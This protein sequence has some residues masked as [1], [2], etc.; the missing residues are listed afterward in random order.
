MSA[1]PKYSPMQEK[2]LIVIEKGQERSRRTL[3]KGAVIAEVGRHIYFN[4]AVLDSFDV[5]GFEPLHYDML[6]LCAAI[7]FADRRWKRPLGWRRTFDVAI[8]VIDLKAW[9]KPEVLKALHGVLNHLT[10]DAWRLTFVQA[11]NLS[12][13]GRGRCRWTSARPRPSPSLTAMV[14]IRVP[15]PL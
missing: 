14:W 11:K 6:V 3:P 1:N 8:P 5:K 4:P 9:Q 10:G 2:R 7:E 13:I 15:S 12:P